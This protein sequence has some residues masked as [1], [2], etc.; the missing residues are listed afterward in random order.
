MTNW[1]DLPGF[2]NLRDV[3]GCTTPDGHV[4]QPDRLLRSDN[5]GGL[6]DQT[7]RALVDDH[8]VTD[9]IDLRSDFERG[10]ELPSALAA[11]PVAHHHVSLYGAEDGEQSGLP[12]TDSAGAR[13]EEDE[14]AR[15]LG[16]TGSHDPHTTR[17]AAHYFVHFIR[18][19]APRIASVLRVIAN[20]DGAALVHC[21][22][23]KDRTGTITALALSTVGVPRDQVL[24]DYDA[25]NERLH[26]IIARLQSGVSYPETHTQDPHEQTTPSDT[27]RLLL[28]CIDKEYG[29]IPRY[30]ETG[31]WTPADTDR[32]RQHLLGPEPAQATVPVQVWEP[33]HPN[34]AGV[35]VLHDVFGI[36]EHMQTRANQLAERG[37][38]VMAPNLYWRLGVDRLPDESFD[39][40]SQA[41]QTLDRLDWDGAV[42]DAQ[43]TLAALRARLSGPVSVVGWSLGAGIGYEL[44]HQLESAG[45]PL[46]GYV[47][48]YGPALPALVE[49]IGAITTPSLFHF[50]TADSFIDQTAQEAVRRAVAERG[51][52]E[53]HS[54]A[55]AGHFFDNPA[56]P[57]LAPEAA[58]EAWQLTTDFLD[59]HR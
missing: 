43:S 50:G 13:A 14:L 28:E 29:S 57:F 58:T 27:M 21:A 16:D 11:E 37:Y 3:A 56:E 31:G 32:L 53:W 40:V 35:V 26:R 5:L 49:S 44:A 55:D 48:Y 22:A 38:L 25:T 12:D 33:E 8:H 4:V 24:A 59:A 7:V 39:D 42:S 51:T 36:T 23:G 52:G 30:L 46:A 9:V 1:I 19:K 15:V 2:A 10:N 20:A 6:P 54:W 41:T 17:L 47:G 34:G 45:T 18:N